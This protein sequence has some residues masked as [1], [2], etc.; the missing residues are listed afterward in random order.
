MYIIVINNY[1]VICLTL[2]KKSVIVNFI[3]LRVLKGKIRFIFNNKVI[4]L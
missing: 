1:L 2:D 3:L 4:K